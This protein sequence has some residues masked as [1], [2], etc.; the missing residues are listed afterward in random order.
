MIRL[1]YVSI[2]NTLNITCS[3]TITYTE[4]S[5]NPNLNKIDEII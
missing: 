2:S 5:K 4:Y 3:K 1:G